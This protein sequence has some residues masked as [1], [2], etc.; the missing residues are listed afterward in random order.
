M[1][2]DREMADARWEAQA[3]RAAANSWKD[4]FW[5][6]LIGMP[7]IVRI[8]GVFWEWATGDFSLSNAGQEMIRDVD[9]LLGGNYHVIVLTCVTASFGVRLSDKLIGSGAAKRKNGGA[10]PKK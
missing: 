2:H 4:E 3:L 5:T 6:I 7:I 8:A 1:K 10:E 9:D